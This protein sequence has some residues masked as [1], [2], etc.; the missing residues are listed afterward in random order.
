MNES[1]PASPTYAI[2]DTVI[3]HATHGPDPT[4]ADPPDSYQ[5]T[6]HTRA[7]HRPMRAAP[8]APS[9]TGHTRICTGIRLT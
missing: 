9:P 1:E 5:L 7:L 3:E 6:L 4:S 8:A 2:S